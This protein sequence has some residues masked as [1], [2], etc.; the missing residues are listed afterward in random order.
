MEYRIKN[1]IFLFSKFE[2][3][4]MYFYNYNKTKL[5]YVKFNGMTICDVSMGLQT[6]CLIQIR[7][8][9]AILILIID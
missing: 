4:T 6:P 8:K 1:Y 9:G 7:H 3:S 5:R 2:I